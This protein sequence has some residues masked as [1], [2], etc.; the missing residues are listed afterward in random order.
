MPKACSMAFKIKV[1][2]EAE[3][4]ENNSQIAREYGLSES[5]VQCW[6]RDQATILSGELK[7]SAKR[8]TR[9]RFTPKYPEL[10]QQVME[11]FSE[12]RDQGKCLI[13]D[14]KYIV[15]MTISKYVT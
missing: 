8:A 2:A 5:M 15:V 3:A 1:I 13:D 12:Q 10:H 7:M 11:W 6:R 9:G 14:Q 4:V